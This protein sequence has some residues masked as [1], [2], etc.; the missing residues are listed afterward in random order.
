M[1]DM[2]GTKYATSI[3]LQ[4]YTSVMLMKDANPDSDVTKPVVTAFSIPSTSTSLLVPVSSFT[5][6]DNKGVTGYLVTESSTAA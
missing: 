5:A 2:K 3:T 6:S 4:P 1:I